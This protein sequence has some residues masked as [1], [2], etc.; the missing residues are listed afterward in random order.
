MSERGFSEINFSKS[1]MGMIDS[2]RGVLPFK[3]NYILETKAIKWLCVPKQV[4]YV[5]LGSKKEK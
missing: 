4:E 1:N 5:C 2:E 3:L